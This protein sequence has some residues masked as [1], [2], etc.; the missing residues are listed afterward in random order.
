M[1]SLGRRIIGFID[2]RHT[3]F[4]LG[5]ARCSFESSF[6]DRIQD[7]VAAAAAAAAKTPRSLSGHLFTNTVFRIPVVLC[8]I[9]YV[10][11]YSVRYLRICLRRAEIFVDE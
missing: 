1:S 7:T 8:T 3:F 4:L 10:G 11:T 6:W 2:I 5:D 9:Q